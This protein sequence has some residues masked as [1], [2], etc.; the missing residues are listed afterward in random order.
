MIIGQES[1]AIEFKKSTG[2]KKEAMQAI[3]AILNKHSRGTL[4]FGIEDNGFVKGQDVTDNTI[5]DVSRWIFESIYPRITPTIEH[6]IIDEKH[7][8]KVS[9]SGKNKPYSVYGDY[10]IRIGTENKKMSTDEL[11]SLIKHNDYS[12]KWEEEITSKTINDIDEES[13]KDFYYSATSSGRLE[14]KEFD[15]EKLLNSLNLI[16]NGYL[17]NAGEALFG[18]N[19]NIGLKVASYATNNKVRI[20]DLK[21]IKGNIYNLVSIA[22]NYVQ[23]RINYKVEIGERKREEIPEIPLNA[24]R[25]IIVNA[26]AHADYENGSDIEIGIHP[27]IIEIYNP[28]TFPD[29]LTPFDFIDNNLHSFVRNKII[30]DCLFRSKD[31]EKSG[32]GFQ[33]VNELCSEVD[34]EW[35]FRK[36]AYGF[37]FEFLR[38]GNNSKKEEVIELNEKEKEIYD[39]IINNKQIKKADIAL[40]VKKSEKTIQRYINSMIEKGYL[41]RVGSDKDGYWKAKN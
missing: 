28:G 27:G 13:L 2:E 39:I 25:E 21:L 7:I 12:S 6:L 37:Y 35:N 23:D 33:R 3:C 14:M 29:D 5:K 17:N 24:L 19:A 10:L 15:K 8:I 36:E 16:E 40:K 26:F 11:K 1:E 9:F 38:K 22:L 31:V 32:T 34:V 4:Y 30:L 18:S 20:T 41:I